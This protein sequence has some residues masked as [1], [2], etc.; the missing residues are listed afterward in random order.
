MKNT[1]LEM[2]SSLEGLNSRVDDTEGCISELDERLE[3]ITQA[4]QKKEKR[5]RGQPSG[6]AVK[7]AHSALAA[8][9]PLFWIPGMDLLTAHQAI[10]WQTS[11]M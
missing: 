7:F 11:H 6:T 2:K 3:E 5:I 1:I 9:G 10:L 4:E 8:E